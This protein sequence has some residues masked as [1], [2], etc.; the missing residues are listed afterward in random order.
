M[1]P[2]EKN[3]NKEFINIYLIL[4]LPFIILFIVSIT[5][6]LLVTFTNLKPIA[7]LIFFFI[8]L[9]GSITT[10][11]LIRKKNKNNNENYV[12]KYKKEYINNV[13]NLLDNNLT[14]VDDSNVLNDLNNFHVF[15][16]IGKIFGGYYLQGEYLKNKIKIGKIVLYEEY[17]KVINNKQKKIKLKTFDGYI[18][19][20]YF[21]HLIYQ[22]TLIVL[23]IGDV[24]EGLL[25]QMYYNHSLKQMINNDYS[26]DKFIFLNNNNQDKT[27]MLPQ[28]IK[29]AIIKLSIQY[30]SK[31]RL[32]IKEN[33]IV[34]LLESNEEILPNVK[35]MSKRNTLTSLNNH[36]RLL[37]I[38]NSF[39]Q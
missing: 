35:Y 28:L 18:L 34:I 36:L 20:I 30:Q 8:A 11:F 12:K 23:P 7:A 16:N 32:Y 10:F 1:S 25:C 2:N 21:N 24:S 5:L 15:S 17:K 6:L 37:N 3:I 4:L 27:E 13:I 14:Y 33:N 26:L 22:D 31:I 9:I 19:N 38:V 39:I 29:K